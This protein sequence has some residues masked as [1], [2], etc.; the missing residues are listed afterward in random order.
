MRMSWL[1]LAM[2]S[3][4]HG[5]PGLDLAGIHGNGQIGDRGIFALAR[6][7]AHDARVTGFLGHLDSLERLGKAANL[8]H[9]HQ[10]GVGDAHLDAL[11]Q[12]LGVRDEQVVADELHAVANADR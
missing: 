5:A 1:Y 2:R 3:L 9:L 4:R 11:L 8:V 12:T 7:V 10:N 6:A